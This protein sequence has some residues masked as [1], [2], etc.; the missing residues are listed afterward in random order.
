[1]IV[2]TVSAFAPVEQKCACLKQASPRATQREGGGG[3]GGGRLA[4]EI[5]AINTSSGIHS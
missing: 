4:Y 2:R 3:C 1:M 5:I